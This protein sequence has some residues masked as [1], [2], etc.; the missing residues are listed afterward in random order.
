MQIST[1]ITFAVVLLAVICYSSANP[2][3]EEELNI[4]DPAT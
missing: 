3:F 1:I 4:I 2:T